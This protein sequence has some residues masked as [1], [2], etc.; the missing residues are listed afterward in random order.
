MSA[1]ENTAHTYVQLHKGDPAPWFSQ[2]TLRKQ[3]L[4]I[5][6]SA[7][8]YVALC[9]FASAA[10]PQGKEA[11]EAV[12]SQ[13]DLFDG[14]RAAF[15]GVSLDPSD[16]SSGRLEGNSPALGFYLDFD[17]KISRAYGCVPQDY[18]PMQG[19]VPLRRFWVIL[20]PM[21]RVLKLVPFAKDGSDRS[22]V[23][24]F[25]R[26]L[27]EP[28][29]IQ[30]SHRLPVPV[31][32]LMLPNVFEPQ[33]CERLIRLYETEGG[34]ESGFMR[35]KQ[36]VTVEV[37]DP[38]HKRRKDCVIND[39]GLLDLIHQRVSRRIVPEIAKAFQFHATKIE[40]FIVACYDAKDGGHFNVHRDNTTRGTAH[41]RFAVSLNLNDDY[42]GGELRFPE[43]GTESI[44]PPAGAALVFSCSLLHGANTVT[45]GKRYVFLPFL[46]DDEAAK[47][48]QENSQYLDPALRP[49]TQS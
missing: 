11:L 2:R 1:I 35:E 21:L 25:I 41:R 38:I 8:R 18:E 7:G 34:T 16:E 43:F 20:D 44:K 14:D 49:A 24:A 40:R 10:T 36:G 30:D 27:P 46:Y 9:F 28:G 15:F 19:S 33:L 29:T 4:E 13:I 5:H 3:N 39:E 12:T 37:L 31:P 48:R 42:E 45:R 47:I 22:E 26:S 23:F 17:G 6:K 32:V